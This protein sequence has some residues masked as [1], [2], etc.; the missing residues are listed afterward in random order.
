MKKVLFVPL[1]LV[2]FF[3]SCSSPAGG[4]GGSVSQGNGGTPI[5]AEDVSKS[6]TELVNEA[7]TALS[8]GDWQQAINKF[9]IAY[10]KNPSDANKIYYALTEFATLSVDSTIVEIMRNKLGVTSYPATLN[11]LFNSEWAKDKSQTALG[12]S[13]AKPYPRYKSYSIYKPKKDVNGEYIRVSGTRTNTYSYSSSI[14]YL[15]FIFD[16][17]EWWDAWSYSDYKK[18]YSGTYLTNVTPDENGSYLIYKYSMSNVSASF[19]YS[20][21]WSDTNYKAVPGEA[22]ILPELA[23]PSWVTSQDS[24]KSTLIGTTLSFESWRKLLNANIVTNNGTGLN[25]TIDQLLSAVHKK[26]ESIK[27]IVDSLGDETAMLEPSFLT[28]LNL[29][30]LLGEDAFEISK[31]E[32]NLLTSALEGIDALL[33]FMAS[34]DLRANLKAAETDTSPKKNIL[35]IIRNSVTSQTLANRS[36]EK[37]ASSKI[38]FIDALNRVISSYNSI[39]TSTK[40]PQVIKDNITKY[41]DILYDGA[42]K[43]KVAIQNGSVLYVP[44][45]LEG[46]AF[47]SNL[48]SS[49]FGIDMGKVFTPG[50]FTKFFERSS[51]LSTIKFFYKKTVRTST[52]NKSTWTW[53]ETKTESDLIEITDIDT[54]LNVTTS[55]AGWK[56]EENSESYVYTSVWY[57]VGILANQDVFSDALPSITNVVEKIKFIELFQI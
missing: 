6:D 9:R 32:M 20:V 51:D 44:E 5:P 1:M 29:T 40:F 7:N 3:S 45:K 4:S 28:S 47:P 39:K 16:G 30:Y 57:Q 42:V 21:N 48:A 49:A 8:E 17:S 27:N 35:K 56:N 10:Q 13:W 26:S 38:L 53:N 23:I 34:Y 12:G 50:Y 19:Y 52:T 33:H 37:L 54:F 22:I 46:T 36:P 25:D 2:L 14:Q 43:A 55:D 31:T 11:A 15:S 41:G 24:Y 18:D